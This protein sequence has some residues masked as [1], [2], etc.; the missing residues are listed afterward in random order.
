[1]KIHLIC[2]SFKLVFSSTLL[3]VGNGFTNHAIA[4][5][6]I[7]DA[8]LP[9]NSV[10]TPD[11]NIFIIEKGTT[12]GNNL[13]HS[14]AEFSLP[15]GAEVFFNNSVDISNIINRVTGNNISNIDGLIRANGTANFFLLNPNG[16]VFGPNARLDIGGSFVSSTADNLIFSDGNFYSATNPNSPPLLTI[17]VPLG[18]QWNSGNPASIQVQGLGNSNIFPTNNNGL[19]VKPGNTIAFLGGNV[20]LNGGVVS[21]PSGRIEVGGVGNG[22][23]TMKPV[24]VGWQ[25]N[26]EQVSDFRDINLFNQ[27][28]L[29]NDNSEANLLGGIQVQGRQ[30]RLDW[31]SQIASVTSGN[32]PGGSININATE[33]LEIAGTQQNAF[34]FSSWIVTQVEAGATGDGG[35]INVNTSQL[36][37]GDGARIQTLSFGEGDAGEVTINADS[38]LLSGYAD[39]GE[40]PDNFNS[41]IASENF[42]DGNGGNVNIAAR[43]LQLEDGGEVQTFAGVNATGNA[44]NVEVTATE[45]ISATN[46][47]P[48]NPRNNSRIGSQSLGVGRGGE[49]TVSTTTLTLQDGANIESLTQGKG[50]GGD[51]TVNASESIFASRVNPFM[52][53]LPKGIVSVTVGEGDGGNINIST[54]NMRIEAGMNVLSSVVL[55]SSEGRLVNTGTGNAGDVTVNVGELLEISGTSSLDPSNLS[56]VGSITFAMGNAG[57]VNVSTKRLRILN[58]G[59]LASGVTTGAVI[60]LPISAVSTLLE[61][62]DANGGNL[63][64]N[65]AESIEVV[66]VEPFNS[67]ASILSTFNIR[68]GNAGNLVVNTPRLIVQDGGKVNS[69]SNGTGNAGQ[70]TINAPELILVSGTNP[71][72]NGEPSEISSS[73]FESSTVLQ[74]VFSLPAVPEGDVGTLT[75]NTNRLIVTDSGLVTVEHD[76]IGNAGSL[77]INAN[78]VSLSTGGMIAATTRAGNGGNINLHVADSLQLFGGSQISA[79]AG[80]SGSGGNIAIDAGSITALENSDITANTLKGTGGSININS[81][82]IFLSADSQITASSGLGV[83]GTVSINNPEIDPSFAIAPLPEERTN[84]AQLVV[85]GCA[86][87]EGSSFTYT[88]RGGLPEDP[89]A[90]LRGHTVWQ[91]LQDY[92]ISDGETFSSNTATTQIITNSQLSNSDLTEATGWIKQTDGTVELVA[93]RSNHNWYQPINC[94]SILD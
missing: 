49:I 88:G 6:I 14:F 9:K 3:I 24:D 82:G 78:S 42:A 61:T 89:I 77:E 68:A 37:I 10:V 15:T 46:T 47:N 80:G 62:I 72:T 26:Y 86:A 74:E 81:Q 90:P 18:L 21:A 32:L 29:W 16:I 79:S 48:L 69:A 39:V 44:G 34:P 25:L 45:K 54:A 58:G 65:A 28:S 8:T 13:F 41:R 59:F 4:Q 91:D 94:Q 5:P 2:C 75:I 22:T 43:Q 20:Y 23:V 84:L 76:G 50:R 30:V 70:V 7:P 31:R 56:S 85:S 57:D 63:I 55:I 60:N 1:M 93:V 40:T 17:N 92:T 36:T 66:G 19:A 12:S 33:L 87:D 51:I 53:I 11:G 67:T 71:Q 83:S 27:S 35:N 38:I 64:V 73:A 52:T